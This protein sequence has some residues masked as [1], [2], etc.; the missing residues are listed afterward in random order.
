MAAAWGEWTREDV[1]VTEL[2]EANAF[3]SELGISTDD[4]R[5]RL[6]VLYPEIARDLIRSATRQQEAEQEY[7]E[8]AEREYWVSLN[9]E[10]TARRIS[11]T[12]AAEMMRRFVA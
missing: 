4:L 9:R 12:E 2:T 6:S 11:P 8:E 7:W 10:V 1:G 3:A 5:A